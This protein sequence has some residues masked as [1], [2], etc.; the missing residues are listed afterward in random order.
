MIGKVETESAEIA[1]TV[2]VHGSWSNRLHAVSNACQRV[3]NKEKGEQKK[4]IAVA[5][6]PSR[7][8]AYPSSWANASVP[9]KEKRRTE[10]R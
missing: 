1:T 9:D 3:H 5:L 4:E 2:L 6:G 10:R 8:N 7:S